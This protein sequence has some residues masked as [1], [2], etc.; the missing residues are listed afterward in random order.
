MLYA[1][2]CALR[3]WL[4]LSAAWYHIAHI[5]YN[6]SEAGKIAADL[7]LTGFTVSTRISPN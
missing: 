5:R 4:K 2:L 3:E 1:N 7:T 6:D